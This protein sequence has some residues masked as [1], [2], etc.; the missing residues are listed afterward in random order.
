MNPDT[1]NKPLDDDEP[2]DQIAPP[3][4]PTLPPEEPKTPETPPIAP[5]G[6]TPDMPPNASAP[7]SQPPKK[8]GLKVVIAVLVIIVLVAVG[9]AAYYLLAKKNDRNSANQAAKSSTQ[10]VSNNAVEMATLNNVTLQPPSNM[11]GFTPNDLGVATVKDYLTANQVCELQLGTL[12]A[13]KLPGTDLGDIVAK[14]LAAYRSNGATVTGPTSAA[15]LI[16][17]D[18]TDS[19]KSYSM[20]TLV[21]D[22]TEGSKHIKSYYSAAVLKNG[23]RVFVG[24]VC[25]SGS[26]AVSYSALA[27]INAKA[28]EIKVTAQ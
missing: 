18:A 24:R 12:G 11:S 14:Q 20:P 16:L 10:N 9:A 13:D 22:F 25:Q 21:F 17:K 15:A 6:M 2:E 27:P 4:V 1:N 7:D 3:T 28:A 8:K 5:T 23:Q 19:K 26:G